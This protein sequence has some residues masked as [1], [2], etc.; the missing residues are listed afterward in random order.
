MDAL[1]LE[2]GL[3]TREG[4]L[5]MCLAEALMRVPDSATADALIKDK[6]GGANW[7]SHLGNSDSVFVNAATWGL[8]LTGG[9][10]AL[11]GRECQESNRGPAPS[12]GE[13]TRNP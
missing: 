10:V 9:V 5:L 12:R 11:D 6:L 2:Y 3:D 8:M 1:F 13:N 4:I 7:K